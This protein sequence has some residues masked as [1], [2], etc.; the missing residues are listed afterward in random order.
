MATLRFLM[1]PGVCPGHSFGPHCRRAE[2][3]QKVLEEPDCVTR[4]VA[5]ILLRSGGFQRGCGCPRGGVAVPRV[6]GMTEAGL[7]HLELQELLAGAL[8][9]SQRLTPV[10]AQLG[11]HMQA[12]VLQLVI[13]C[14]DT[15]VLQGVG[16]GRLPCWRP[17]GDCRTGGNREQSP[18]G[19]GSGQDV[20]AVRRPACRRRG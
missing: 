14:A 1:L 6:V 2:G 10:L 16:P 19:W 3:P 8:V 18:Q 5:S 11:R 12:L 17:G 7:S 13:E 15:E 4:S 9:E 20:G